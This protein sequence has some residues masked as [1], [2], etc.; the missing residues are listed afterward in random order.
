MS[1]PPF[2]ADL[3]LD[4][5][6]NVLS[7][8]LPGEVNDYITEILIVIDIVETIFNTDGLC[9]TSRTDEPDVKIPSYQ[10]L[11]DLGGT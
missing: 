2:S 8:G 11:D 5:F 10:L 4:F 7:L 1:L 6:L 9:G 3:S